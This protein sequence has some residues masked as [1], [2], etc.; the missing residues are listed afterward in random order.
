MTGLAALLVALASLTVSLVCI[1]RYRRLEALIS[2]YK[3]RSWSLEKRVSQ[4][5]SILSK[6]LQVLEDIDEASR[7]KRK[8]RR[9][10]I[11]AL[12]L[13]DGKLPVDPRVVQRSIEDA[14]KRLA[15]EVGVAEARPQVVY[16]DPVRGAVIIRTNHLAKSLVLASLLLIREIG[17]VRVRVVPLR[18]AGTIRS[19]KRYLGVLERIPARAG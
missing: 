6:A 3:S 19:A 11:A 9:R 14:V 7:L 2:E 8:R 12:I 15:G 17:G 5:E 4:L 13:Y 1:Y 10:Y 16:Y 18:T